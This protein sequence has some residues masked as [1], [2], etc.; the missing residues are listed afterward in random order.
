MSKNQ[1]YAE[2]YAEY[3]M[4]QMRRY[5]IPA[6]VTLAQGI[7]ESSNGQSRLAQ[8]EN[9]HFGIKATPAW[10]AGGG[11]YGV[12]A[13][14]K[15][16]EKFC[17]YDSVGDSYEHHSRFLKENSRYARCFTLSPD[18][19]KGWT[20]GIEQAGYATG[21]RYAENLQRII[22][23]N[24]LQ[25]Y[26]RL[27]MQEMAA[28]GRQ[29]GVENNPLHASEGVT[30][31]AG[32]SFPVERKEFLFVTSAFGMRQDPTDGTK[33]Q[34]HKGLDI[35]CNG[36]AVLA[37]ENGGKVVAVN[38]NRNTPGGKSLTVEYAR[39]DGSKVQCTYMHLGEISVKT[40]DTVQAGG[41]LGISGNT[42][43][44]T[45]G[46]HLHFGVVNIY[47]DGTRR[48]ID[49]AA[50]LAEIAQKGNIKQQV[51]H[52]GN[53]LLAKY[54][55]TEENKTEK[56]LSPDDWMKKLLSSEDGGVGISGCNDPIVEMAMTAFTSL[57]LL[58][59]QIDNRNEEEQ[60]AAISEAMDNRR[61]DLKSLLPGMKSCDLTIG[62]NGKALLRADNGSIQVSRELTAAELGRLSATLNNDTLPEEAKRLRVTGL[63]NTVILSEAASQNFEQGM[64]Q[65]QGQ[66]ENLKR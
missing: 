61:I 36:D 23:Q 48:D 18:D 64:S 40:G 41:Q 60:K 7:L 55:G 27:V 35:R 2:Q 17:S 52:N 10:I 39:A 9:N 42:G 43:T 44:R 21:G 14:D 63:L 58:A 24:G 1:E 8:R 22:E 19:Y 50:Y 28:Q 59:A 26:D 45:T 3:A 20:K 4:E 5:G 16:N 66:A 56:P 6:S 62:E 38:Q 32:Y 65:Q 12:Y 25:Q 13:D 54:K 51:L 37:T 46:E 47:A 29:F 31:A 57:M 33:Q 34:M 49:P 11:R 15:P 30:N 53:D